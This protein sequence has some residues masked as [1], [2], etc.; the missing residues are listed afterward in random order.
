LQGLNILYVDAPVGTG[1]SYSTTQEGYHI[2]DLESA[3][4]I[5]EFLKKVCGNQHRKM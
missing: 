3:S 4:Q 2:D 5:Y 1:F